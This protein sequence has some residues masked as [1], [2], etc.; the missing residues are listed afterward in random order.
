MRY[1][2]HGFCC[3]ILI[4]IIIIGLILLISHGFTG[5]DRTPA[6]DLS[7]LEAVNKDD[8]EGAAGLTQNIEPGM[9]SQE[10][11]SDKISPVENYHENTNVT[12]VTENKIAYKEQR[13][14]PIE[15]EPEIVPDEMPVDT[16][17]VSYDEEETVQAYEDPLPDEVMPVDDIPVRQVEYTV[18]PTVFQENPYQSFAG[19]NQF[20]Q[21]K[22][23]DLNLSG[24]RGVSSEVQNSPG[25]GEPGE[26]LDSGGH[27][28]K[29]N[30]GQI[31]NL[32]G[33]NL[34]YP[35][36]ARRMGWSGE[37]HVSFLLKIDG[38]IDEV[39]IEKSCGF[40]VLDKSA[41]K[42]IEKASPFPKPETDVRIIIPI[43]Y[44]LD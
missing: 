2:K 16:S 11:I 35:K 22:S 25:N 21:G 18:A 12:T 31:R 39:L 13:P 36:I 41:V 9:P 24:P 5:T 42:T 1:L 4:H 8:G 44:N 10:T 29:L 32:L 17:L 28:L 15:P 23:P 40:P 34:V 26:G 6:I 43:A 19:S 30:Y 20:Y 3:S 14:E 7:I 33:N 38:N 27:Y 37:V